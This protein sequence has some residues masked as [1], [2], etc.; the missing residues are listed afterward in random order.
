MRQFV[1]AA[2]MAIGLVALWAAI[3]PL[4][5]QPAMP[6]TSAASP[7]MSKALFLCRTQQG[8]DRNCSAALA[9]ALVL[10]AAD[11]PA[12]KV[13]ERT[14]HADPQMFANIDSHD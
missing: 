10:E 13:H 8:I 1:I 6:Q 4:T 14:C 11:K 2:L 5:A 7:A 12:T 9:R 3:L